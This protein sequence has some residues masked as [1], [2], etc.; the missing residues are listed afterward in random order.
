[1]LALGSSGRRRL[2]RLVGRGGL[3]ATVLGAAIL[4]TGVE[5]A[6]AVTP[7]QI[8]A[9]DSDACS[10]VSDGSVWCWGLNITAELG[11]G[12]TGDTRVP[13]KVKSLPPKLASISVG[14]HHVC[15][16]TPA[17]AVWCWG[18][19]AFGEMGNGSTGVS[20]PPV[21]VGGGLLA[22]QVASGTDFSCA[23]TPGQ[24]VECWGDN[25]YGE[26]G[27]G[28]TADSSTPQPVTGLTNVTQIAAGYF[29]AC[30]LLSNGAV[31]CWG[32]NANGE[33]G[34]GSIV[35]SD[36]PVAT[37]ATGM[38]LIAAGF[39]DTCAITTAGA[40]K[41][42]GDNFDGE[43]GIGSNTDSHLPAAVTGLGSGVQQVTMGESHTCA[44][45]TSVFCWGDPTYGV[46]GNGQYQSVPAHTTPVPVFGLTP[47]ASGGP[48]TPVQIAAGFNHTC[49]AESTAQVEC[50][51]QGAFGA[52][53]NGTTADR[54]IPTPVIGLP[55][56]SSATQQ[57][58]AGFATGCAIT[59]QLAAKC[60]GTDVG[61]G[62]PP[63]TIHT[64][65]VSTGLTGVVQVSP[66]EGGCALSKKG[67]VL[68]W[69]DNT[70]GQLGNGTDGSTPAA[71]PA[72]VPGLS[73][74]EQISAGA[75][76]VCAVVKNGGVFC[77][78]DNGN[79][80]I[81]D[82]STSQR[83]SPTAVAGLPK[84]PE[85]VSVGYFHT[86]AVL[87]NASV[88]CWG[89]NG[90]GQLGNA[91]TSDSSAPVR[92][93]NPSA[94]VQVVTGEA[95]SCALTAAGG[96][97]C[98]GDNSD[99]QLGNNSTTP[100]KVPVGVQGLSAG[101]LAITSGATHACAVMAVT[102]A[103]LC[104]G[105][106]SADQLGIGTSGGISKVPVGVVALGSNG[107][108]VGSD[109]SFST[110]ATSSSMAASCWGLGLEG[111]LGDGLN[112][113]EPIPQLV[114]GL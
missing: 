43:L 56:T 31:R 36:V 95:F 42:W 99:G 102:G 90:S 9:G 83:D 37:E 65:A 10:L 98:W 58:S 38:K 113:N 80:Q 16:V 76:H 107:L 54:P 2:A 111:Q 47:P 17:Q 112:A 66:Y 45:T 57:I 3:A 109:D 18:S 77:W 67:T 32:D 5:P 30:A 70:K 69:G 21:Q 55:F 104:W 73:N 86:C 22:T 59:L 4:V 51:G 62:G 13:V 50:W 100:S 81:G 33:L 20:S 97:D 110:C 35:A 103:V 114:S 89:A 74:V 75:A 48:I 11:P 29:H 15:A 26:L 68:C 12:V 71:S 108:S 24:T 106:N 101:V 79:G 39:D 46:D 88:F 23:L 94:F 78:G 96:V 72:T 63:T 53:G 84:T 85:M 34:D 1:M 44:L 82:G 105:D 61:D 64:T 92:V 91:S 28:S 8:S 19:N 40:L 41:C 27:D 87:K 49:V 14:A 60:W 25:N 93:K 7:P 52:L 6:Q